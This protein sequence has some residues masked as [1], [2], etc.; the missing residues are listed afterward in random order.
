M[1][2]QKKEKKISKFK[3]C[4]KCKTKTMLMICEHC[5]SLLYKPK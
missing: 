3:M 4:P 2:F 5:G 1:A